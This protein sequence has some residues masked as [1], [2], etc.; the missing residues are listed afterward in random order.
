MTIADVPVGAL[1]VMP[2]GCHVRR[3]QRHTPSKVAFVKVSVERQCGGRR[4][5]CDVYRDVTLPS[6]G[7]QE[8][9]TIANVPFDA[10]CALACGCEVRRLEKE[11]SLNAGFSRVKVERHC[12][13]SS[14]DCMVY[15]RIDYADPFG[16][17]WVGD[18]VHYDPILDVLE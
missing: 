6:S 10:I 7:Q 12:G 8:G 11:I 3:V 13:N 16:E 17:V 1:C 18:T 9:M 4:E 15:G 14:E 2:C 5:D